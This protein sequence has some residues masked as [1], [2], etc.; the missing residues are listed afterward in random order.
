MH[1]PLVSPASYSGRMDTNPA[2]NLVCSGAGMDSTATA[3][4]RWSAGC[5]PATRHS[6]GSRVVRQAHKPLFLGSV[7][8]TWV[9]RVAVGQERCVTPAPR[10]GRALARGRYV[11]V[12]GTPLGL[13]APHHGAA[14]NCL[15]L[16][17]RGSPCCFGQDVPAQTSQSHRSPAGRFLSSAP[18]CQEV[19]SRAAVVVGQFWAHTVKY[20]GCI[21]SS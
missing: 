20:M 10:H 21:F 18:Q 12:A 15:F 6:S 2:P 4:L 8:W 5:G 1:F 14:T 7:G 17:G 9:S 13:Q 19:L 11:Q 3:M 16:C